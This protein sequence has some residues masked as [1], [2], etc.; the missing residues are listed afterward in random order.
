M[1]ATGNGWMRPR[2]TGNYGSDYQI[3]SIANFAGIWANNQKE[4]V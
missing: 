1:G 4:V 2:V 3:R